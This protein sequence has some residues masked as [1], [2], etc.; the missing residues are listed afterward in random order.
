M[1]RG[2]F[3]CCFVLASF[4]GV[5]QQPAF[6]GT[7]TIRV[8][9]KSTPIE[10]ATVELRTEKDSK[11]VKTEISGKDGL[12]LFENVREGTYI[13][14]ASAVGFNKASTAAFEVSP[15]K[16]AIELPA[17]TME[18]AASSQLSGVTVTAKKPFIQRLNDRIVV[19]VEGSIVSA[20]SS[21]LDVLE[22][23]PGITVDQNDAISLRG[24]A[25]VI[26]MID[27]K[28]SPMTGTDLANYLKGLPASAIERI[29][30][31][32]NPSA[33]YDAAGN[34]G[35]IDIRMKKDQRMGTNGTFNAGVGQGKYPK[36]STGILLNHR[37]K[38]I[39]VFGSY[40]YNY[41]EL[42]NHLIINRNFYTNG[43]LTGSDDKDNFAVFPMS[44]HS[45]RFGMDFFPSKNTIIGFVVSGNMTDVTRDGT[46]TTS[47]RDA[48]NQPYF[49]F[50]SKTTDDNAYK[51]AV[52]NLN[53]KQTFKPGKELT[54]DVDLGK[55]RTTALTRTSSYFYELDGT[56][57]ST[58]KI[59]DGDQDGDLGFK[60]AKVDY[61]N[62]V[63]KGMKME[64]GFKTSYVSSDNDAKFFDGTNNTVDTTKTNRF[65]Y[66]EY[67]NAGYV[68]VS[69]EFKKFNLQVG[70]RGERTDVNTRQVKRDRRWDSGYLQFFPSAY[71]NYKLTDD[72]TFGVSVSRRI[73]RPGYSQLNPFLMQIDATIYATGNPALKPQL[74]W[75][76]EMS[77][78]R[79]NMNFT[80]GY[81]RTNDPQSMVLSRILD[82]IPDF[83]IPAGQDSNITVQIPVNLESSDYIGFT[84][85]TPIRVNS[86]WNMVNNLN[87][88]YNHFNGNL[89][90][91]LLNNGGAAMN[92]RTN[93]NFTLK[94][95]WGAELNANLSTGGRNGYS[96]S[97][98]SWG[99]AAGVQKTV[100]KGKGTVRFNVS[101]IFWTN[102]PKAQVNYPGRYVENWHAYRDT[103]VANLN[104]IYRF[105]NN[106][107]QG[108]RNR[109]TASEE[110]TRRAG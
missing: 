25:G 1:A 78:T 87:V 55:Y 109:K 73:D 31:I 105:G 58:D 79:K 98:P 35:I 14:T 93:N 100:L 34:S 59:L 82:V 96:I 43:T 32:T 20:G 110:E 23:S 97:E 76:Y 33:K 65:F 81:S 17:F 68:N 36:A 61:V 69:R 7:V 84:A 46:I 103:R 53:F 28:P 27:G 29:D 91:A 4:F 64:M 90:G 10:G 88:Y 74:T 107:V 24:R 94:K 70:L 15:A 8:T 44:T 38:S 108:A 83:E 66:D 60:T 12:T 11:L 5:A 80:L 13:L 99:L 22:Q 41:R 26:I 19:N 95:G 67:N 102:L 62:S 89:G 21:A 45:G 47:V 37:S 39:N 40:N 49:N 57:K 3:L 71:F 54:A 104:F 18:A 52:A 72:Q 75:S 86:W 9:D 101:D 63:K 30:I 106:K 77:Y 6:N 42:M 50:S 56:K 2:I 16:P 85:T 48:N 51:N 92:V